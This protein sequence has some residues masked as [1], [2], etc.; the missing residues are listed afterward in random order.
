MLYNG[1]SVEDVKAA[2]DSKEE[3]KRAIQE[4]AKQEAIEEHKMRDI[5]QRIETAEA[6]AKAG[7]ITKEDLANIKTEAEKEMKDFNEQQ[8]NVNPEETNKKDEK[9]NE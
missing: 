9:P 1:A 3:E 6:L 8:S 5:K 2:I 7:V 4:K